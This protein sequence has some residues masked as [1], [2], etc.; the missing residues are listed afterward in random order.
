MIGERI[1]IARKKANLSLRGLAE[2]VG[3]SAQAISKYERG[4]DVPSSSI[5]IKLAHALDVHVEYFLRPVTV[6]LSSPDYRCYTSRLKNRDKEV[7]KSQVQ[8][9]LERYLLIDEITSEQIEFS[10]PDIQRKIEHIEDVER[11]ALALRNHWKLGADPIEHLA[12]TLESQGIKVGMVKGSNYFDSLILWANG[13]IPI[14][15]IKQ[16]IPGDR[17]RLS[18]AHELGHL[19]L[20]I[21]S[22]WDD[23]QVERTVFRFAG[24]FL[25]PE[26]VVIQELGEHRQ[27]LDPKELYLL[28]HKYGIS[29]QAWIY[30]ARDLDIIS[31][32][33]MRDLF[34]EFK[35]RGWHRKE[36]GNPYPP[37]SLNRLERL[38]RKALVEELISE[39]RAIE[40]L[41]TLPYRSLTQTDWQSEYLL[42]QVY[43]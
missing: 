29:M 11:V 3:V 7:I 43:R 17:Q 5:L 14:I 9:W 36:P 41:G 40:I 27:R 13:S 18:I 19:I 26:P 37:E 6:S 1:K 31:E 23:R 38:V 20:E 16:D 42:S 4:L 24:A 2:K 15:A 21:P 22:E 8:D 12:E 34:K 28:K 39:A 32:S 10:F 33:Q 30:R 35:S 25:V